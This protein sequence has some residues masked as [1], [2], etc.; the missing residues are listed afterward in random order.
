MIKIC[1]FSCHLQLSSQ[2]RKSTYFW[3]W[4]ALCHHLHLLSRRH[5]CCL[6]HCWNEF[7]TLVYGYYSKIHVLPI[8]IHSP[9]ITTRGQ[10]CPLFIWCFS[11]CLPH[12]ITWF[13]FA[14]IPGLFKK[15]IKQ[16]EKMQG[17]A[18]F[19][20][21]QTCQK[22]NF[23]KWIYLQTWTSVYSWTLY[24]NY[25]LIVGKYPR[26]QHILLERKR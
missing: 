24:R 14:L 3:S 11:G 12:L 25:Y 21:W 1:I 26:K 20:Q 13:V 22:V 8:E 15:K 9:E 5:E 18:L 2:V 6:A 4:H 16:W 23:G 10:N 7:D 19:G 17:K